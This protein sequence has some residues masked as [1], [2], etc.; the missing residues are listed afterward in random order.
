MTDYKA[1]AREVAKDQW[2]IEASWGTLSVINGDIHGLNR[3]MLPNISI[4][5]SFARDIADQLIQAAE[6]AEL[7][8][9]PRTAGEIAAVNA[10]KRKDRQ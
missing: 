1:K 6:K 7:V 5:P 9:K 3:L 10:A 4:S 2:D 8:D